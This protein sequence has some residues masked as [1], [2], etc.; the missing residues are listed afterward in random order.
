MRYEGEVRFR[1]RGDLTRARM[2]IPRARKILGQLVNQDVVLGGLDSAVRRVTLPDGTYIETYVLPGLPPVVTIIST[3]GG[4]ADTS[5]SIPSYLL[6][7]PEG[8][9]FIPRRYPDAPSGWGMPAAGFGDHVVGGPLPQV[10]LNRYE[11]NRY[12]D[13]LM[14]ALQPELVEETLFFVAGTFAH[15]AYERM[16]PTDARAYL[17]LG[18]DDPLPPRR[19]LGIFDPRVVA[20]L[21]WPTQEQRGDGWRSDVTVPDT[22]PATTGQADQVSLDY[23]Q[24]IA[25]AESLEWYAH[26]AQCIPF[27]ESVEQADELGI[28]LFIMDPVRKAV[29]D[30]TNEVRELAGLKP[31]LP[32]IRGVHDIA[33]RL[34]L[35]EMAASATYGHD[36]PNFRTGYRYWHERVLT[37]GIGSN[38]QY[39]EV[40]R[41]SLP[42][43]GENLAFFAGDLP[44]G[45]ELGTQLAAAWAAS[46]AHY[47]NMVFDWFGENE[48]GYS[49]AGVLQIGLS[50]ITINEVDSGSLP[51]GVSNPFAGTLEEGVTGLAATQQFAS[52]ELLW[53]HGSRVWYGT[54]HTL[55]FD[56]PPIHQPIPIIYREEPLT[57]QIER[58][59]TPQE[60]LI[61]P[62][63]VVHFRGHPIVLE[64]PNR[65]ARAE[66][67]TSVGAVQAAATPL[68]KS[69]ARLL[70]ACAL[71]GEHGLVIRAAYVVCPQTWAEPPTV[72][73]ADWLVN[74]AIYT[75]SRCIAE[76][77]AK[78]LPVEACGVA[79]EFSP[80]GN[81]MAL[82]VHVREASP[83]SFLRAD[84]S[85][86]AWYVQRSSYDAVD[87][88]AVSTAPGRM[89]GTSITHMEWVEVAE[90]NKWVE[91]TKQELL[92]S[93]VEIRN[94]TAETYSGQHIDHGHVYHVECSGEYDAYPAYDGEVLK[95]ARINVD[96]KQLQWGG[97]E[98]GGSPPYHGGCTFWHRVKLIYPDAAGEQWL[99]RVEYLDRDSIAGEDFFEDWALPIGDELPIAA[100]KDLYSLC[101][102]FWTLD[103]LDALRPEN[104]VRTEVRM[105]GRV[106]S[107]ELIFGG[108]PPQ[109]TGDPIATLWNEPL[110]F[111]QTTQR[112]LAGDLEIA[113]PKTAFDYTAAEHVFEGGAYSYTAF[114]LDGVP[115]SQPLSTA[116]RTGT[117]IPIALA[118]GG[119]ALEPL[120]PSDPLTQAAL[121]S[122]VGPLITP[123]LVIDGVKIDD[124]VTLGLGMSRQSV[125]GNKPVVNE[126]GVYELFDRC[127]D[128]HHACL[129]PMDFC[130]GRSVYTER[131]DFAARSDAAYERSQA[132]LAAGCFVR[133]WPL[134][135]AAETTAQP[136]IDGRVFNYPTTTGPVMAHTVHYNE[137]TI[138]AGIDRVVTNMRV[139]QYDYE[140]GEGGYYQSSLDLEAL[141]GVA[142]MSKSIFP[143]GVL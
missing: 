117:Q 16:T 106:M 1:F 107:R 75:D 59:L 54:D 56:A 98:L 28:D 81:R 64:Y 31:V 136:D 109:H 126:H 51:D 93:P 52:T 127:R 60:R 111:W 65:E 45:E 92:V 21:P 6:W 131:F 102:V 36:S 83:N 119:Q 29:F 49:A 96:F 30:S 9:T 58:G 70:A 85:D 61:M 39:F 44:E 88:N 79:A 63:F 94:L 95:F 120:G 99:T 89:Y 33:A 57:G 62:L 66:L 41:M 48:D 23:Q 118:N 101:G 113:P 135:S 67:T 3:I 100:D 40:A 7:L 80:S 86:A 24:R 133:P 139:H 121:L 82:S 18:N 17:E 128:T 10:L 87:F 76:Y 4:G 42:F 19:P 25:V 122:P 137:E 50:T 143:V 124:A 77:P 141:T 14:P 108:L 47:A 26:R 37:A 15:H 115:I 112:V 55:S 20:G 90:P 22:D 114:D 11:D 38:P 97:H 91:F 74:E 138:T 71:A 129:S 78:A 103:Y 2:Y 84:V 13:A 53:A 142:G 105:V 34:A 32:Q 12:P 43:G 35:F 68:V 69:G 110:P 140:V 72:H 134:L 116:R 132:V 5:S 73:I 8:F 125:L 27:V 130:L 123:G 46:P 104:T